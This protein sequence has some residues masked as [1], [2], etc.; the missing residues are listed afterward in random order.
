MSTLALQG[1]TP[2]R[3]EPYSSW[4]EFDEAEVEAVVDALR[5][6]SWAT[7]EGQRSLTSFERSFAAYQGAEYCLAVSSGTSALEIGLRALR[8]PRGSEVI[9]SPYTYMASP[10]AVLN[11]GLVPIFVDMDPETYNIDSHLIEAAI[12]DRTGAILTVHFGG[13]S[14]D[15]GEVLEI[16]RR[17][18]LKVIEDAAHAHG[19]TWNHRGLGTIGDVGCFSLG[20]GKN[21]T[22]GVGG[23]VMTNDLEIYKHAI[24][25]SEMDIGGRVMR[26]GEMG[27][28]AEAAEADEWFP[29]SAGNRR[30]GGLLAAL[31]SAQ[32]DRLEGQTQRRSENGR[33]LA[34]LLEDVDGLSSRREDPYVT[35]NANHLHIVRYDAQGFEGLP[36]D[37]FV[38][39]MQAEGLGIRA[40]Y[41]RPMNRAALFSDPNGELSLVWPRG[42]GG[43]DVDYASMSCP[44]AE[45]AC[46]TED[47]WITQNMMLSGPRAMEEIVDGAEKV[48][49]NL[50]TLAS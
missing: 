29:Y 39:A 49:E 12:T 24:A 25:Y 5:T 3:T 19:S 42:D 13:L 28:D 34:E 40:G 16:A 15:M 46:A 18:D 7:G 41:R 33:Y 26:F 31:A 30:L 35:R 21:L 48:R 1:G 4:P 9:L 20:P 23:A 22:P 44:H 10:T 38:E 32:L 11:V 14:C 37:R 43:P 8:L 6:G 2:I 27:L 47:L 17:R 36:R 50:S 45:R